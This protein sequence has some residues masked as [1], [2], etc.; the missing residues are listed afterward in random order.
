MPAG[1]HGMYSTNNIDF[2]SL[3]PRPTLRSWTN[4]YCLGTPLGKYRTG[5]AF[6]ELQIKFHD[7]LGWLRLCRYSGILS[8][9]L[10]GRYVHGLLR[11][12]EVS[13]PAMTYLERDGT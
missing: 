8:D 6:T 2:L 10:D 13:R 7:L 12:A 5:F 3:L 4:S 9:E 1:S 11:I